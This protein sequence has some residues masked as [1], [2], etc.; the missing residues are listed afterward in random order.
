MYCTVVQ[1]YCISEE[2]GG[3]TTSRALLPV[4][5]CQNA[6]CARAQGRAAARYQN[7]ANVSS[8]S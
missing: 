7:V 4:G 1:I 8:A 3:G 5:T 2:H 6:R